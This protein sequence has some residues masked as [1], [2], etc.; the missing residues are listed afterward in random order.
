M[1]R[2]R[3]VITDAGFEPEKEFQGD[4]LEHL[5]FMLL[6]GQG[7]QIVI[8]HPKAFIGPKLTAAVLTTLARLGATLTVA[9]GRTYDPANEDDVTAFVAASAKR[10]GGTPPTRKGRPGPGRP[11]KHARPTAEQLELLKRMWWEPDQFPAHVVY[12]TA[13]EFVGYEVQRWLL[14]LWVSKTRQRPDDG[15]ALIERKG[16]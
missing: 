15:L 14:Q 10:W 6:P 7:D 11:V 1:R 8:A 5:G 3:R 12:D 16:E 2:Q 4:E 13:S 9:G